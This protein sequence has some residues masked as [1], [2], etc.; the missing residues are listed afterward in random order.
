MV[1][2]KKILTAPGVSDNVAHWTYMCT[3]DG[4]EQWYN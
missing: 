1:K 3:A 4:N 2:L